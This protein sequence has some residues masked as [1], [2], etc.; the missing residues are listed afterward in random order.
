MK[1]FAEITTILTTA[2]KQEHDEHEFAF[3]TVAT[4]YFRII[5]GQFHHFKITSSIFSWNIGDE[6]VYT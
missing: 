4:D 2:L 6:K 3:V 5:T 1:L